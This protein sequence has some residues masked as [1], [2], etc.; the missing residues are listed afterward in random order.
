MKKK[1]VLIATV[2]SFHESFNKDN[3]SL[4]QEM[5]FEVYLVAND[6]S[7][8]Y[9]EKQVK[10]FYK[11]CDSRGIRIIIVDIPRSPFYFVGL[12]RS[13]NQ[14]VNIFKNIQFELIH[15]HT[16][17]GGLLGRLIAKRFNIKNLYTA[18]GFHFYNGASIFN[19][20]F[21]FNVEK[22]LSGFTDGIVTINN[23]D[24]RLT[25]KMDSTRSFY[26]PGVGI[27]LDNFY[28]KKMNTSDNLIRFVSVGEL[29]TNKNHIFAIKQLLELDIAFEYFIAGKGAY[30][31]RLETLINNSRHSSSI[32]LLG[33][34]DDVA[35]LLSQMDIMIMPSFRE[36]LPAA[37]MEAMAT[38]LPVLASDIRGNRDL[39]DDGQG[40]FLFE[41]ENASDFMDKL[42]ILIR[43]SELRNRMGM[44]NL[45][46]IKGYDITKIREQMKYVYS[47]IVEV[48]A[49][50]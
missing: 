27:N 6:K 18:H 15:S 45:E 38:G 26:V 47:Q 31:K 34:V 49:R 7:T 41:P 36:G 20:L 35:N 2:L 43:D 29:N 21:L 24:Y 11:Y 44:Y 5:D 39:I 32:K 30:S 9:G 42:K 28:C 1:V 50:T 13:Y 48:E 10:D 3:I 4:L 22:W 40:G 19:W 23:E 33:Y 12:L 17:V 8:N 46:K 16:P 14:L 25:I 37:V